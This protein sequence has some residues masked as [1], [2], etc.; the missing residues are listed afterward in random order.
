MAAQNR[1]IGEQ[2]DEKRR[3]NARFD[4]ELARLKQLW[5]PERG[6]RRAVSGLLTF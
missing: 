2:E 3:L 1:F 6:T 4:E 5:A